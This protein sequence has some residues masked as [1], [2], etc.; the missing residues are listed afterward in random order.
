MVLRLP[1]TWGG[2]VGRETCKQLWARAKKRAQFEDGLYRMGFDSV[3]EVR[4]GFLEK[5][6]L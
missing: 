6:M 3:E 2:A 1:V 4:E 5:G